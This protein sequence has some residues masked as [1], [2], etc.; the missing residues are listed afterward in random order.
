MPIYARASAIYVYD[1]ISRKYLSS[2]CD[3]KNG[4]N[5]F[6]DQ[7]FTNI[8]IEQ[9]TSQDTYYLYSSTS[10]YKPGDGF[11]NISFH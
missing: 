6:F 10:R 1:N 7:H 9:F 3:L 2:N 4:S 5:Y 11:T 8:I